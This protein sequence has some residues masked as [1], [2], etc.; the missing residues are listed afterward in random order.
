MSRENQ[1]AGDFDQTVTRAIQE[2]GQE[3]CLRRIEV[4]KKEALAA[5]RR[6]EV[7]CERAFARTN[8]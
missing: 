4:L 6:R 7:A 5:L 2:A 8:G 1:N 3:I